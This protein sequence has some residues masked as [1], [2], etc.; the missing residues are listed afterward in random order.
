[1]LTETTA[2]DRKA[3]ELAEAAGFKTGDHGLWIWDAESDAIHYTQAFHPGNADYPRG[4]YTLRV[5]S[6]M[7][8]WCYRTELI[9]A[10]PLGL[11]PQ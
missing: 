1:M 6:G 7:E 9:K 5:I 4:Y 11:N 2:A 8:L 10:I 3:E